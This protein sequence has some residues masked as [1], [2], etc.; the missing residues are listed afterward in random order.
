[1]N[2]ICNVAPYA[3]YV[4]VIGSLLL[5]RAVF[6]SFLPAW[7]RAGFAFAA[8]C[9]VASGLLGIWARRVGFHSHAGVVVS[10]YETFTNGITFGLLFILILSGQMLTIWRVRRW[11][12]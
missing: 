5:L 12:F 1:M 8:V 9:G 3:P 11:K 2:A 6:F 10:H 7:A 4:I